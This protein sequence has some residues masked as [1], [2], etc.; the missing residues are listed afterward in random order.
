LLYE[1]LSSSDSFDYINENENSDFEEK[2]N[3]RASVILNKN[4]ENK[5][6]KDLHQLDL[7]SKSP[8]NKKKSKKGS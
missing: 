3:K 8:K 6:V 4:N 7:D 2:I 1:E 5:K